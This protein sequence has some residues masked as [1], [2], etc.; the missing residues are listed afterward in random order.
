MNNDI[1]DSNVR[2]AVSPLPYERIQLAK[3]RELLCDYNN[4]RIYIKNG[5][6]VYDITSKIKEAITN[7]GMLIDKCTVFVQDLGTILIGDALEH[8][9]HSLINIT[10]IGSEPGEL[11]TGYNVDF[12]S[13]TNKDKKIQLVGFS[14]AADNTVPVKL[15]DTIT[16]KTYSSGGGGGGGED[17]VVYDVSPDMG[18]L[19]LLGKQIQRTSGLAS[20]MTVQVYP[21]VCGSQYFAFK[22]RLDTSAYPLVLEFQPNVVFEYKSDASVDSGSTYVFEFETYNYGQSWLVKKTKY[23]QDS[24]TNALVDA[25]SP[26]VYTKDEVNALISWLTPEDSLDSSES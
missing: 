3:E 8:I 15:G 17:L 21:P 1:T 13:I 9:M 24:Y 20:S 16:W 10:D 7:E 22:W 6:N 19:Q 14:N 23:N 5:E 4:G 25:I 12:M 18:I 2:I 26:K 11:V